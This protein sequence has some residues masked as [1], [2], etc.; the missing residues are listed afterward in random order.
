M[1]CSRKYLFLFSV[2]SIFLFV[3]IIVS[4]STEDEL[5]QKIDAKNKEIQKLE[6]EIKLYQGSIAQTGKEAKTLQI[7]INNLNQEVK[8]LN[9]QLK[10]TQTKIS[11]KGLEIDELNISIQNTLELQAEQQTTLIEML[12]QLNEIDSKSPLEAFFNYQTIS[13]LFDA[14][15][16]NKTLELSVS[17][18]FDKL[19]ETKQILAEKK[20]GAEI[21]KKQLLVLKDDLND[22]R[23]LEEQQKEKKAKLLQTTKNKESAYQKLLKDREKKRLAL[24][25]EMDAIEDELRLLIDVNSLPS[26][27]KGIL[28]WPVSDVL[29]TQGF[30]LTSFSVTTN[31][32]KNNSHNG[33]DFRARVGTPIFAAESGVIKDTGNTDT[34]CPGG[35]YGRFVVI[36]DS[37]NLS[38]LYGHLSIIKVTAGQQ[39]SRGDII[40][41]S[42]NTGYST[43][44]HL[45]FTVYASN[46]FR[47][48]KTNSCGLIPAGGYLNPL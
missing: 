20:E 30:G 43:G 27:G 15:E 28:L 37:N 24:Q 18:L 44:P 7:A 31:V 35:A 1:S 14:I 5:R 12:N 40:G 13:S 42:G 33:V 2:V 38:T 48:A 36:D 9:Y 25:R 16:K 41:L 23:A 19:R 29:I 4:A 45:H 34:I 11:K 10:L 46:T 21:A 22:Q 3:G 39:V 17:E 8:N 32:Y 6:T 26:K 47:M